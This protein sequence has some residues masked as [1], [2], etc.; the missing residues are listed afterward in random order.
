MIHHSD[1][2]VKPIFGNSDIENPVQVVYNE[3]YIPF[4]P[5]SPE[6]FTSKVG[7]PESEEI[8]NTIYEAIKHCA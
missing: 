1:T 3:N 8:L 7:K 6:E 5:I 2:C 4:D